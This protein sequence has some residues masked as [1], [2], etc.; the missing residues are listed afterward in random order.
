M[1]CIVGLVHN[2]C[3]YI[4]GDSAGANESFHL[5]VRA[6]AKVFENGPMVMGFT[7]SFRMGQLLRWSLKIPKRPRNMPVEKFMST[8]FIDAVRKCLKK[9]GFAEVKDSREGGGTFIVGYDGQLFEVHD[10]FQVG[11]N[12][13]GFAAV[14]SGGQVALGSLYSSR[15]LRPEARIR[16]A[17]EAA[18]RFNAGVRGPFVVKSVGEGS[19]LEK[20]DP[21]IWQVLFRKHGFPGVVVRNSSHSEE[22]LHVFSVFNIPDDKS[23]RFMKFILDKIHKIAP[24]AYL[25]GVTFMPF[26]ASSTKKYHGE[27]LK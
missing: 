9:G 18:E 16:L 10:D 5:H 26:S 1:T 20:H 25:E 13:D 11:M 2:N 17:L 7:S 12:S 15:Q 8:A 24:A 21:K 27:V 14:G 23:D 6:D 19:E 3:V 22:G 4:G